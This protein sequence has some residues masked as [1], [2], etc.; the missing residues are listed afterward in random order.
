[1]FV[2]NFFIKNLNDIKKLGL[3][4]FY[5]KFLIL[6]RVIL[7]IPF[8]ILGFLFSILI[9][10]LSPLVLV[11]VNRLISQRLGH[12]IAETELYLSER[13]FDSNKK[14]Y[15]DI[16]FY[17]GPIC[18][19]YLHKIIKKKV[20][21]LPRILLEPIYLINK[22]LNLIYKKIGLSINESKYIIPR[23]ECQDRDVNGL[24]LKSKQK[25]NFFDSDIKKG[26]E[27]LRKLGVKSNKYVCLAVRDS[28]YLDT[29]F[30]KGNWKYL[31][32]RNGD[33][34]NYVMAAEELTKRGYYVLRM[35]KFNKKQLEPNNPMIIDYSFS[36]FQSDFMDIYLGGT[37]SFCI[38]SGFG[39]DGIPFVFRRP[40][41]Y[42]YAPLGYLNSFVNNSLA[43]FKK[44]YSL[45]EK[46]FLNIKEIYSQQLAFNFSS[47]SLNQNK[48]VLVENSPEEIKDLA[49]E[50]DHIVND[51]LLEGESEK[52]LQQKFWLNYL[53]LTKKHN[54]EKMP[55]NKE[56]NMKICSSF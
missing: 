47:H 18:N 16:F 7:F 55:I 11:R 1:M 56:I 28:N 14:K 44:Y 42:V 40:I 19:Y 33:I 9:R 8:S 23:P 45:K 20:L 25:I 49:V 32:F 24:F 52:I 2:I 12:Y 10:L 43:I 38:S 22:T 34:K 54:I 29:V 17:Y 46:K 5:R 36:K 6:L 53:E 39:F 4:E 37:C 30:P 21:V 31:D 13:E 26:L 51:K 35:G 50:M 27:T 41:A 3:K 48:I 15:F